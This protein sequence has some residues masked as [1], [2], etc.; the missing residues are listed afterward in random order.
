ME[1]AA[2]AVL[3][4]AVVIEPVGD[5]AVLLGLQYQGV[6]LDGVHRAG[7]DLEEVSFVDGNLPDQLRPFPFPHHFLQLFLRP[8]IVADD[9]GSVILAVTDEPALRLA[10]TAVLV[11]LR[12]GIVRMHLDAQ[13]VLSI[14]DLRQ[15]GIPVIGQ[16]PEKLRMLRPEPGQ[17]LP[18]I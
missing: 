2:L 5:G 6:G 13:V 1:L 3:E 16:V 11:D 7:V 17:R 12:V 10:Q 8:G 18:L 14:D 15:Q 9:D 4:T